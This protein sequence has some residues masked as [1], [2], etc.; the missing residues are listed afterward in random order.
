MVRRNNAS[1]RSRRR[2]PARPRRRRMQNRRNSRAVLPPART[3]MGHILREVVQ[4]AWDVTQGALKA[5]TDTQFF[6]HKHHV[7]S[8]YA[9][10]P[11]NWDSGN[12]NDGWLFSQGWIDRFKGLFREY[13]VHKITAHYMPYASIT[14]MGDYV[15]DLW[16]EGQNA[17]SG[18]W[19]EGV[20]TPASVIRKTGTP[21]RLVWYPTE[22]ED[23]N[24]HPFGD[25]HEWCRATLAQAESYY[26]SE[27]D[28]KVSDKDRLY[29][30]ASNVAGKIII[31]V[32]ASFRGKSAKQKSAHAPYGSM[33]YVQYQRTINCMCK[34]CLRKWLITQA[35]SFSPPFEEL[36]I[37]SP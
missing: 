2:Q 20:G 21:S 13:K 15:F 37:N 6:G 36:T 9:E 19:V 18:S 10:S 23:R 7:P 35:A 24:W 29:K 1:P 28:I 27:P 12:M 14:S 31:E 33:E 3:L 22:P 5:S 17:A 16:D 8:L 25:G 11:T 30:E 26:R 4:T 34:R 32:D